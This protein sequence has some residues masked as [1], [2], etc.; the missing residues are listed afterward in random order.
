M[1]E[2]RL[3]VFLFVLAV[4]TAV[5][6]AR[7]VQLQVV[8]RAQWTSDAIDSLHHDSL[9][10]TTRGRLLDVRGRPLAEDVYCFDA[11]VDYRA[12]SK[13]PDSE[14]VHELAV[15]RV[16]LRDGKRPS[17]QHVVEEIA[18][19]K[20]DID[21]MWTR[22]A[23]EGGM[24]ADQMDDL[25]QSIVHDVEM[26]RRSSWYHHFR[27][28]QQA[29][30]P[31]T[32][33]SSTQPTAAPPVEPWY[34][35]WLLGET[36]V[37]PVDTFDTQIREQTEPHIILRS[38]SSKVYNALGKDLE[39]FPG[40]VLQ[41]GMVRSYP[42]GEAACHVLGRLTHVDENDR[43][44]DP[45]LGDDLRAYHLSDL[46]G[47]GG[48]EG[49]CEPLLRGTRGRVDEWAS[50]QTSESGPSREKVEQAI[51]GQD[52][53]TTLDVDLQQDIR[54]AF[55]HV[56][57]KR[58]PADPAHAADP[59]IFADLHGA[60]VV[61]DIA[62]GE[63]RALV[64]APGFDP[65]TLDQTYAALINDDLNQPLMNRATQAMLETGSTIKPVVGIGAI[66]QGVMGITETIECTGFLTVKGRRIPGGARCWTLSKFADRGEFLTS[67]HRIP[68]EDPHPTGFLTFSDA[69]QR[70]CNVF[71][72]NMG[73]RLGVEG[74]S[75]WM[76]T[77]GLG[78]MTGIGISEVHG[79]LP[80]S[81]P[82]DKVEERKSF[83][84]LGGIGQGYVAATPIQ[85]ANVAATV[86]RSGM[87]MRPR[88]VGDD[89]SRQL[90]AIAALHP[91]TQPSWTDLPDSSVDL[92]LSPAAVAAAQDGMFRVVNT[93][94][95]TGN[96]LF[97][98]NLQISGKTGTAQAAPYSIPMRDKNGDK[99]YE[100][101]KLKKSFP[102]PSTPEHPNPLAPWYLG[103]KEKGNAELEL[104]HSWYIG[105]APS[106]NP[107][108][109]FAV[110]VEYGGSGGLA[111]GTIAKRIIDECVEHGYVPLD[112]QTRELI[113]ESLARNHQ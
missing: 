18:Q 15:Q 4:I 14:W 67:H 92:K 32:R 12:I 98:E 52:V 68:T 9:T 91:S 75:Y 25:R 45:W 107:R 40:L 33:Q 109:A 87:W 20:T 47:R 60:A 39:R 7:A 64:S 34:R 103:F 113:N 66:T 36:D 53:K 42:F 5:L 1:F 70:S 78:R 38:I 43:K 58:D 79:R 81:I 10:E 41:P 112:T 73:D 23:M 65:N 84:L 54:A 97:R 49:L 82:P 21:A 31:T 26:R 104:K 48:L 83:A 27:Q 63:V 22:L 55:N 57:V 71:F 8:E 108:I 111:A 100:N 28:A 105:Y 59:D 80:N 99:I 94:G 13:D 90:R 96:E 17:H 30:N 37:A 76:Q 61:I 101:G 110:L 69:L 24:T 95:G 6:V 74:L 50:D 44:I 29:A 3:K 19:V 51:P 35:K 62:S 106:H 46:I 93:V 56:N 89:V 77:F 11:C 102:D 72:E 86:A 16:A 85:M 2:R 88:L